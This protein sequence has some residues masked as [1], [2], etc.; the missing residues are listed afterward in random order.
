MALVVRQRS[1]GLPR[2]GAFNE[3][4]GV[5][6]FDD[7]KYNR[8]SSG[9]LLGELDICGDD[10][11]PFAGQWHLAALEAG[12]VLILPAYH[13]HWVWSVPHT[14]M[15]NVWVHCDDRERDM[16]LGLLTNDE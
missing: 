16:R 9:A 14:V 10:G 1:S 11:S 8:T 6:P 2:R 7:I 5:N 12:D 4:L 13:W 15:T 3:R